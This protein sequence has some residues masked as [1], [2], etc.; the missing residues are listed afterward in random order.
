[1]CKFALFI[2]SLI[3][4]PLSFGRAEISL[5]VFLPTALS[6]LSE[7]PFK[8]VIQISNFLFTEEVWKLPLCPN[9]WGAELK[10]Q[11][12]SL[13]S[14]RELGSQ[15]KLL[16]P[17]TLT[18]ECREIQLTGAE[19]QRLTPLWN[20]CQGMKTCNGRNWLSVWT[21]LK[22]KKSRGTQWLGGP[23]TLLSCAC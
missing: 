13:D 11:Q 17:N 8:N 3:I 6:L 2:A 22:D 19:A 1:M 14:L 23:H 21:S 16:S 4:D 20:Q 18:G 10:N 12:L 15:G 7:P 5:S 9:K